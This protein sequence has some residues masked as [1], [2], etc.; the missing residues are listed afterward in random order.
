MLR[1]HVVRDGERHVS[2]DREALA[3]NVPGRKLGGRPGG[4]PEVDDARS[5]SGGPDRRSHRCAPERV[6]HVVGPVPAGCLAERGREVVVLPDLDGGVGPELGRLREPL[7][8]AAR[9]DHPRR[10]QQ[11]RGLHRHEPDGSRCPEH[12]DRL[13][14]V[15]RRTPGERKPAG[16]PGD[17]ERAGERRVDVSGNLDSRRITDHGALGHPAVAAQTE[18]AAED[19]DGSSVCSAPDR[20]APGHVRE[21][22]V[23]RVVV[24]RGDAEVDRVERRREHLDDVTGRLVDLRERGPRTER[25]D[26]CGS[27]GAEPTLASRGRERRCGR[28]SRAVRIVRQPSGQ[29]ARTAASPC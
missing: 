4:L 2:E 15:E 23:P 16:E 29:S 24:P 13:A 21:G 14:A 18:P 25:S 12:E 26:D 27:H 9:G 7:R 17:A 22:R 10:A 1:E 5:A 20:F 6:E 11:L 8:I 19:P 28:P 3:A